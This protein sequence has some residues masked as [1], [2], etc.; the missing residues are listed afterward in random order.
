MQINIWEFSDDINIYFTVS[1]YLKGVR[2][3][4]KSGYTG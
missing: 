4:I 3:N 1:L 2:M